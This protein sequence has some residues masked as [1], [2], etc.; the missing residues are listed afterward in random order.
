[1]KILFLI[2]LFSFSYRFYAQDIELELKKIRDIDH[3]LDSASKN[4]M[5]NPKLSVKL[6]DEIKPSL[7]KHDQLDR[8]GFCYRI[9]GSAN[10]YLGKYKLSRENYE[11]ALNIAKQK[12]DTINVILGYSGIGLGYLQEKKYVKVDSIFSIVLPIAE[13]YKNNNQI[14]RIKEVLGINNFY[15]HKFVKAIQ[16]YNEVIDLAIETGDSSHFSR[17]YINLGNVYVK[18]NQLDLAADVLIKGKNI[19]EKEEVPLYKAHYYSSLGELYRLQNLNELS[20]KYYTMAIDTFTSCQNV[21]GV[22]NSSVNLAIALEE[23]GEI[24][25]IEPYLEKAYINAKQIEDVEILSYYYILKAKLNL[26]NKA[27]KQALLYIDTAFAYSSKIEE[28]SIR[29]DILE[30]EYSVYEALKD[31]KKSF[32]SYKEYEI[33]EDSLKSIEN[34]SKIEEIG[35]KKSM[36]FLEKEKEVQHQKLLFSKQREH[37]SKIKLYLVLLIFTLVLILFISFYFLRINKLNKEKELAVKNES[38][39]KL[40]NELIALKLEKIEKDKKVL[41]SEVNEKNNRIKSLVHSINQKNDLLDNLS[42]EPIFKERQDLLKKLKK[43][44]DSEE[45]RTFFNEEINQMNTNFYHKLKERFSNL[46]DNDLKL[47]SMLKMGLS[48]KEMATLLSISSSSVDVARS[49]LRKKMGVPKEENLIEFI[50]SI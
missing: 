25:R 21:G 13:D 36:Q 4:T 29:K 40:N 42:E 15:Q 20:T 14:L 7:L 17:V 11:L 45:E 47:S 30:V 5:L 37:N 32:D 50:N 1:M 27:Y 28:L 43:V 41:E 19:A 24:E 3:V 10:I 16:Y 6:I 8:L 38:L 12:Q 33:L 23:V 48:S 22:A 18:S 49:R 26:N 44:I 9:L 34:A 2:L 31:Y 35:L 39:E 46:S